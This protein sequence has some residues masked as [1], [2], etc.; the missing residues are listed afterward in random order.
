MNERFLNGK[1]CTDLSAFTRD[2]NFWDLNFRDLN[3]W[4]LNFRD[5]N[6][7]DL[8]FQDLHFQDLNFSDLNFRDLNFSDLNFL[9]LNF[10]DF[11]ILDLESL[12]RLSAQASYNGWT[13]GKPSHY[14]TSLSTT[15]FYLR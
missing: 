1:R 4:D 8:N 11:G 3:F 12:I 15:T 6:L 13:M 10:S 7:S 5:L 9:D 2:L 14:S